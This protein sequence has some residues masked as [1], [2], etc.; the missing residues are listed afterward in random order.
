MKA[1][2]QAATWRAAA[3]V[4]RKRSLFTTL[5][6]QHNDG[7]TFQKRWTP[8][9]QKIPKK[10]VFS[11]ARDALNKRL[12][13]PNKKWGA[14]L[15]DEL[16]SRYVVKQMPSLAQSLTPYMQKH[17]GLDEHKIEESLKKFSKTLIN[18]R[19][20]LIK[21]S[22]A[23]KRIRQAATLQEITNELIYQFQCVAFEH[24]ISKDTEQV[25]KRLMDMSHP[26]EWFPATRTIERT[27]HCHVGPTNS[28]KTYTAL[29]ALEK[30][31]RGVYAGPLRL[32][33]AEV[34]N[35][36]IAK[37]RA[38]ALY[39]GEE[40]RIPTHTDQYLTSCTA[41]MVPLNRRFDVAVIDEIQLIGNDQRG[42]AWTTALLGVQ[43]TEVHVCGEERTLPI[44]KALCRSMGDKCIVHEYQRLSPLKTLHKTISKLSK[45]E[46]GDAVI[47]FSRITLHQ[48]K[49]RIEM[50]TGRRCA[51]IYGSMPPEVRAQQ[52]A[53]FNDPSNEYDFLVGSD[54]IGMGLN[55]EIRRII[56]D[57]VVKFD[58][59]KLSAIT[60]PEIKQIGGRAGRF[61]TAR[62][63][64]NAVDSPG[65][66]GSREKVGFVTTRDPKDLKLVQ[67]AFKTAPPLITKAMIEPPAGLVEQVSKLYPRGTPLQFILMGISEA[68]KTSDLYDMQVTRDMMEIAG[69]IE[70]IPL[71]IHDRLTLTRMPVNL[72]LPSNIEVLQALGRII[73][74]NKPGD[75]L[76]I[77]EIPLCT[78]DM[79]PGNES[80][81]RMEYLERLEELH[82]ALNQY[83]WLS[84]RYSGVFRD[85]GMAFHARSLVE[86]KLIVQNQYCFHQGLVMKRM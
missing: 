66:S 75:L 29:Q 41:E 1:W 37:G 27:I 12:K 11:Q 28:G 20:M 32:L 23:Y 33:A 19:S 77:A 81:G 67:E 46:K 42:N 45:L 5:Q 63:A 13:L 16:L 64:I 31:R 59:V 35:R 69:V 56:F 57:K 68:A 30:S 52:A 38:C 22:P 73:A 78:L 72:R 9:P 49:R 70:E 17:V 4:A 65:D 48:L 39:T 74:E 76:K 53:L 24:V 80:G 83:I 79:A 25:Q 43:A 6:P 58:G 62:S 55:L 3:T 84:Y 85:Q 54:A 7:S 36:M 10:E 21:T 51:I 26:P 18:A 15:S 34:Y 50:D 44:I 71:T 2:T 61:R 82:I 86:E 60:V 14:P 40:V 8:P 47:G